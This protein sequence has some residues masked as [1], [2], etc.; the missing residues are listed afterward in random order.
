MK[1]IGLRAIYP[2]KRLSQP[3][4]K[5]QKYPYLPADKAVWLPW[6]LSNTLDAEFCVRALEEATARYGV[7]AIMN[8]DQECQYTSLAFTS[9]LMEHGTEISMDSVNRV[10]DN[11]YAERLWRSLKY[12]DSYLHDYRTMTE[13]RA[14]LTR[15][16]TFC[17]GGRFHESL[18]YE[19][20]DYIWLFA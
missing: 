6:R 7:P 12:E 20:H 9:V 16:F 2:G 5:H 3:D 19:T 15:Y 4:R 13:L 14:G 18:D 17:N 1:K 11:I 10:L 8:T